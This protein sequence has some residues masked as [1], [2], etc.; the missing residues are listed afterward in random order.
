MGDKRPGT[1]HYPVVAISGC[2]L[3]LAIV[4]MLKISHF[5]CEGYSDNPE[6]WTDLIYLITT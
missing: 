4:Y 5:N 2:I 1:G 3:N 6:Q